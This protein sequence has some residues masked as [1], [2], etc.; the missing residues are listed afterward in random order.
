MTR[1]MAFVAACVRC[2]TRIYTWGLPSAVRDARRDEIESD[3]WESSHDPG[4]TRAELTIQMVTRVTFGMVDDLAWRFAQVT[5]TRHS[6]VRVMT[7]AAVIGMLL[8]SAALLTPDVVHVPEPPVRRLHVQRTFPE[9]PP[10]PPPP[11]ATATWREP[12]FQYGRTS[13]SIATRG[14]AP[15]LIKQVQPVYPPVA[16]AAGLEGVVLVQ[17]TITEGGRVTDVEVEPAGV[18]GRSAV[19]AVLR[20]EFAPAEN[21][22]ERAARLTVRVSFGRSQ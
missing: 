3:L 10:P 22:T 16:V 21:G 15:V 7:A 5:R 14:P 9:P 8:L 17:G 13:Y 2:W 4:I 20:W 11:G 6:T 12:T 18:L 1:V 19:G